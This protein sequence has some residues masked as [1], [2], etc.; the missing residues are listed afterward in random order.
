MSGLRFTRRYYVIIA[1]MRTI[2]SVIAATVIFCIFPLLSYADINKQDLPVA[3]EDVGIG[4]GVELVEPDIGQVETVCPDIPV[5]PEPAPCPEPIRVCPREGESD[6]SVARRA[7]D[8]IHYI[9]FLRAEVYFYLEDKA[10]KKVLKYL[11]AELEGYYVTYRDIPGSEEALYLQARIFNKWKKYPDELHRLLKIIYEY[12]GGAFYKKA[13]SDAKKLLGRKLKKDA[14]D[15]PDLIGY[16][17]GDDRS[18]NH[19]KLIE[20]FVR[21]GNKKYLD[22]QMREFDEFLAYY[23]RH[24]KADLV[25]TFKANNHV[26]RK[27]YDGAAHTLR[28]LAHFYPDSPLRADS[29]YMLGLVYSDNLKMHGKAVETFREVIDVHPGS[30]RAVSSHARAAELYHRKLK[31]PDDA[32]RMLE[33]IVAKYRLTDSAHRAFTYMASIL[34]SRKMY[35]EA[36]DAFMRQSVMFTDSPERATASLFEAARITLKYLKNYNLTIEK[37]LEVHSR[38]PKYERSAEALYNAAYLYENKLDDIENAKK[39]YL[40]AQEGYPLHKLGKA[41]AK[42]R[43]SIVQREIREEEKRQKALEKA[44][45]KELEKQSK[46]EGVAK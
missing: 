5:C 22:L 2:I 44:R 11:L 20:G 33:D 43:G 19:A 40:M 18:E 30:P 31:A 26:R 12:Q 3:P 32:I 13:L 15:N 38:Y 14:Q 28:R 37:F 46:Q 21:F 9:D 10:G 17:A 41:S 25:M 34:E 1:F 23:P 4:N 39:Y 36:I 16:R 7:V 35:V 45:Q 29:L 6:S 24:L 42:R 8:A 27:N